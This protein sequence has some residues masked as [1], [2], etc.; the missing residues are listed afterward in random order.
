MNERI[1]IYITCV[2]HL[3]RSDIHPTNIIVHLSRRAA[4]AASGRSCEAG[5]GVP[6]DGRLPGRC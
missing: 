1:I 3:F 6:V 5:P 2:D 4:A